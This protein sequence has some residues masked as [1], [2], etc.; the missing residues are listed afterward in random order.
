M[1]WTKWWMMGLAGCVVS[2]TDP[3][4]DVSTD[5]TLVDSTPTG[6]VPVVLIG[7]NDTSKPAGESQYAPLMAGQ[8]FE[9]VH[10]PQNGWHVELSFKVENVPEEIVYYE[11]AV[12]DADDQERLTVEGLNARVFMV[13]D[14]PGSAWDGTGTQ[15]GIRGVFDAA[16]L[17]LSDS[18][19]SGLSMP[20]VPLCG[21][22]AEIEVL[23]CEPAPAGTPVEQG[24]CGAEYARATLPVVLQPDPADGPH[25]PRPEGA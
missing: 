12:R 9:M 10:G 6:D 3:T 8:D 18:G 17:D 11:I 15:W 24:G 1:A 5:D 7:T 22:A 16:V 4:D 25:C 14:P 2:T 23:V 20:W 21:R 19:D 13:P